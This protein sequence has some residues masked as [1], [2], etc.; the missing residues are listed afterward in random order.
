M[1]NVLQQYDF[2]LTKDNLFNISFVIE[3]NKLLDFVQ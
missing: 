3:F 1:S 2:L